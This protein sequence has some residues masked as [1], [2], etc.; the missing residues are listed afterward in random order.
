M[1]S[2]NLQSILDNRLRYLPEITGKAINSIDWPSKLI[3]IGK[4]YGMH[5]DE[6]EDFQ[7]VVLRS[8]IGMVAPEKFE[9]ELITTLAL[10]PANAQKVLEDI[11]ASILEPIHN[12]VMNNGKTPDALTTA[13]IVIEPSHEEAPM[14][15]SAAPLEI[16]SSPE[17]VL[18]KPNVSGNFDDFFTHPVIN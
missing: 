1:L 18:E 2:T 15:L 5:V 3:E 13:G 12:F 14:T 6:M 11:N 8:M 10:S 16:P 17:P 9:D 7:S 4:K